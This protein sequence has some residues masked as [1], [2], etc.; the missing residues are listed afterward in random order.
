MG[1]LK[2]FLNDVDLNL[3]TSVF[4]AADYNR[5][6]PKSLHYHALFF[7]TS[8]S[9]I[10]QI[11]DHSFGKLKVTFIHPSDCVRTLN[12]GHNSIAS[13]KTGI[14]QEVNAG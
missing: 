9:I 2:S 12:C 4:V 13:R 6:H 10:P 8:V 7:H 3:I 1:S 14:R 5:L 11:I